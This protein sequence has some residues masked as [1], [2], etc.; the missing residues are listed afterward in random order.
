MIRLAYNLGYDN[1][2]I[3]EPLGFAGGLLLF[4]KHNHVDLE[5]IAHNSQAIHSKVK[6]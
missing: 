3:V 6:G 5:I 2:F 4:W 1:H